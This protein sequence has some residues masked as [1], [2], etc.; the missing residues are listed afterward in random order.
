MMWRAQQIH[1]RLAQAP[2]GLWLRDIR[3]CEG[4]SKSAIQQSLAVL[5]RRRLITQPRRGV[6]ELSR[7]AKIMERPTINSRPL[8]VGI[9]SV[10]TY[11]ERLWKTM[12]MSKG[13]SLDDLV[14][15]AATGN[16]INPRRAA[17]KY[18]AALR[19]AGYVTN[20]TARDMQTG[21]IFSRKG[22]YLLVRDSGP[23]APA[24]SHRNKT[25]TD[26][27]SGETYPC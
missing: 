2:N 15:L 17:E 24:W 12:R 5:A 11:R 3:R 19:K 16:E 14:E 7:K 13:F 18:V 9:R 21:R 1:A 8:G 23:L 20:L 27:N 10:G 25:V 22:R 26:H 6:Y 4:V